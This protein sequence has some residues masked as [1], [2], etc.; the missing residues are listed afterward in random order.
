MLL[1]EAVA[2]AEA[3]L[4]F[5]GVTGT[6]LY[7]HSHTTQLPGDVGTHLLQRLLVYVAVRNEGLAWIS[8]HNVDTSDTSQGG[9]GTS[10]RFV[11]LN[12]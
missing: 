10:P 3:V 1:L 5:A 12:N 11:P 6:R 2:E 7:V 8:P 9:L 4:E